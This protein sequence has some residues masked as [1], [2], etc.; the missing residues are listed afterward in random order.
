MAVVL[1]VKRIILWLSWFFPFSFCFSSFFFS[2][3]STHNFSVHTSFLFHQNFCFKFF[4]LLCLVFPCPSSPFL[5]FHLLCFCFFFLLIYF[6]FPSFLVLRISYFFR[7]FPRSLKSSHFGLSFSFLG[8]FLL[9][10]SFFI[11]S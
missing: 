8:S 7:T 6:L 10:L 11:S 9:L 4:F 1:V 3:F 2:A 5:F